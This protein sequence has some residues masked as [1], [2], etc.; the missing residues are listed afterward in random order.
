[1]EEEEEDFTAT[2]AVVVDLL[3]GVVVRLPVVGV[4]PPLCL[5]A[6]I[7]ARPVLDPLALPLP[8]PR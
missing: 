7:A 3:E 2:T 5:G 8:P 6:G 1:M 4:D